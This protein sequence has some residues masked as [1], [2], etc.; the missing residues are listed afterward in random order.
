MGIIE[1]DRSIMISISEV[2]HRKKHSVEKNDHA[3]R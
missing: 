1:I 2:D 3:N